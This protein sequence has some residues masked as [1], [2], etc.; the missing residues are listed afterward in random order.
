[1]LPVSQKDAG[2]RLL[3]AL[4]SVGPELSRIAL[5]ARTAIAASEVLPTA[6]FEQL[7]RMQVESDEE[8][9]VLVACACAFNAAVA[10]CGAPVLAHVVAPVHTRGQPGGLAQIHV[11]ARQQHCCV[12]YLTACYVFSAN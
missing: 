9:A 3:R 2:G 4:R 10:D 12:L 7:V 8:V 6:I 1:M 5:G 11:Q